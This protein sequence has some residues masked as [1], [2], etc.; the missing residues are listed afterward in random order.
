M[1]DDVRYM[2]P[3]DV[4]VM[5]DKV[6]DFLEIAEVS[7]DDGEYFVSVAADKL[8]FNFTSHARGF[9]LH[10]N[11][12]YEWDEA[13]IFVSFYPLAN[14]NIRFD[15]HVMAHGPANA[16]YQSVHEPMLREYAALLAKRRLGFNRLSSFE[17]PKKPAPRP[18]WRRLFG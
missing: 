8:N 17:E 9:V 7:H 5:W 10:E 11:G 18:W 14:K 3:A 1:F 4:S 15:T 12:G 16:A 6:R 13:V 2:H